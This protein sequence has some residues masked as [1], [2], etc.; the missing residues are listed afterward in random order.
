VR[1]E[2]LSVAYQD[3]GPQKGTYRGEI[4]FVGEYGSTQIRLDAQLSAE[5]IKLCAASLVRQTKET[6]DVMAN[7]IIEQAQPAALSAPSE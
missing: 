2:S 1:L 5:L 7:E 6:A 3:Y 4:K